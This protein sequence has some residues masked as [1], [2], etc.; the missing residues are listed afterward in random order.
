MSATVNLCHVSSAYANQSSCDNFCVKP[1]GCARI[2]D[3]WN[4]EKL[5]QRDV[6]FERVP[7]LEADSRSLR[8]ISAAEVVA[9]SS[10]LYF[11]V[12]CRSVAGVFFGVGTPCTE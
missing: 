11:I 7:E 12:S 10:V 4:C 5:S 6:V 8:G 2:L 9:L 3:G 1:S